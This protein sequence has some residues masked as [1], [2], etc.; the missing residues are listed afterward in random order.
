LLFKNESCLFL[1]DEPETH[2][3][4][5]WKAK[6]ISSIR[7]CFALEESSTMREMLITTHSPYLVSDSE[8]KYVHVFEKDKET[9]KVTCGF[10]E[11]Q[12]LGASVNKI[13]IE[14]FKTPLTI[15]KHAFSFL[16]N[17]HDSYE[18]GENKNILLAELEDTLGDSVE[19]TLLI[20]K[21]RK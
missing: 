9:K 8:S 21:L 13:T 19:K 11:F 6:F 17:I 15:G 1:L 10:P 5:D 16:K 7:H 20:H 3:N 2:F 14:V 4:P 12:T 18:N